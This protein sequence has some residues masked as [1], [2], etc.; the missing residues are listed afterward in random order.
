MS[1]TPV[2][3]RSRITAAGPLDA[4]A[5]VARF[6]SARPYELL[7]FAL[8]TYGDGLRI[9]CSLGVEDMV[10]LH[11]AARAGA[12]I[13]VVPR[14]FLLDTG[15]LHQESYDLL[16]RAQAKYR[17]PIDVYFPDTVRVE[18][19][20]RRQGA[21]G[22]YRSVDARKECCAV[23]KLGPLSRALVGARAWVT[24]LRR[25]QSPTR[26]GVE[27]VEL[28][29]QSNDRLKLNPLASWT[30]AEVWEHAKAKGVPTHALHARGFPS[31]GCAP[32]TRAIAPGEDVRAGRWWWESPESKECGLHARAERS[33]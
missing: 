15:R 8:E 31:I 33:S 22:F 11:E 30:E 17:V 7:R 16:D 25:E 14:V 26:A 19:L 5:L 1:T 18:E 3:S 32:C 24:G 4:D 20:V 23:R 27:L 13:G 12:D 9:A 29:A 6:A 2:S 28:D 21:N 10:V